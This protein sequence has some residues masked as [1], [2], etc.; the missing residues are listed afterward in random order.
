[1]DGSGKPSCSS[2]ANESTAGRN[3]MSQFNNPLDHV[4]I[5]APCKADWEQMIG[6]DRVRFCGQCNLN[7]YNLSSMTRAQAESL[8]AQT[9]GRLCVR[10]YRRTDGSIL[11]RNCPVGLRVIQ[12]RVSYLWKAVSA[13]VLSFFAG[14]G[15]YRAITPAPMTSPRMGVM[16]ETTGLIALMEED[17]ELGRVVETGKLMPIQNL[18]ERKARRRR[19]RLRKGSTR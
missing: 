13:A 11:T 3:F 1:M 19:D 7:V 5:A 18:S 12:R 6:T 9:E 2:E 17:Q 16:V 14:L 8:I 15:V 10:F 4:R